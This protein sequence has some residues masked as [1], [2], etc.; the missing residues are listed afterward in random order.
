[1]ITMMTYRTYPEAPLEGLLGHLI[2]AV[3]CVGGAQPTAVLGRERQDGGGIFEAI[4][5][6]SECC[7]SLPRQ[8]CRS[9]LEGLMRLSCEAAPRM[10]SR[11]S[12][13]ASRSCA[14]V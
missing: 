8:F 4:L 11:A 12:C 5:Q 13:I 14:G 6:H 3:G 1:M 7:V 9:L 2:V 10:A